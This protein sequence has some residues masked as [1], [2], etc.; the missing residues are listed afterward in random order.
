M[1]WEKEDTIDFERQNTIGKTKNSVQAVDG[2]GATHAKMM[3]FDPLLEASRE[4]NPRSINFLHGE[5]PCRC[6][7]QTVWCPEQSKLCLIW[8]VGEIWSIGL[9][10]HQQKVHLFLVSS[11]LA[12]RWIEEKVTK[13]RE[14]RAPTVES[15]HAI[16]YSRRLELFKTA[17]KVVAVPIEVRHVRNRIRFFSWFRATLTS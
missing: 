2:N 14:S 17:C 15:I 7:A 13:Y 6:L 8:D 1:S 4:R 16:D 10:D 12:L 9:P 11:M 3:E 5:C